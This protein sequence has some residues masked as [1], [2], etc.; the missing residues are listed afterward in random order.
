MFFTNLSVKVS[1]KDGFVGIQNS[2]KYLVE[3]VVETAYFFWDKSHSWGI[4]SDQGKYLQLTDENLSTINLSLVWD[5]QTYLAE[6]HSWRKKPHQ[7]HFCQSF[8]APV[9][10]RFLSN[11]ATFNELDLTPVF[12]ELLKYYCTPSFVSVWIESVQH[13][14]YVP[15]RKVEV[16]RLFCLFILGYV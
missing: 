2:T 1:K 4:S 9:K 13:C 10:A 16:V 3:L 5:S 11:A 8:P 15:F 12:P 7:I 14:S 6:D